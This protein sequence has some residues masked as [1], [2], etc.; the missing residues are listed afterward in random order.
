MTATDAHTSGELHKTLSVTRGIG[1]AVSMVVGSG[2]L[3][4]P[5]LAFA[6]SG[7]AALYAWIAAAV[8]MLP[9]LLVFAIFGKQ[10]V[11]GIM[12]GAVKG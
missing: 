10:I 4:L 5:G 12:Q 1:V 9:L 8:V 7:D 2:L 11:G 6:N 3:V